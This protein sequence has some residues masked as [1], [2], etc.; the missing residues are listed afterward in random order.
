MFKN[1]QLQGA[2]GYTIVS[3][4]AAFC[5]VCLPTSAENSLTKLNVTL[6]PLMSV[7]DV[8]NRI[9]K[10]NRLSSISFEERWNAVPAPS[11]RTR[12][13]PSQHETPWAETHIE[14]IPFSCELA[15]SRLVKRST[16]GAVPVI[17]KYQRALVTGLD[18]KRA[19][20]V[21]DRPGRREAAGG[22]SRHVEQSAICW[23][24]DK[25]KAILGRVQRIYEPIA[26]S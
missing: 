17:D 10:A 19:A 6:T 4:I 23:A 20:D 9:H 11:T 7:S 21:L 13:D 26:C 24:S 15:F 1:G 25:I 8:A 3:A 22:H 14:K 16:A 12:N 18:D 2:V 5:L